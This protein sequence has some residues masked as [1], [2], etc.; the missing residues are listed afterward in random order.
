MVNTSKQRSLVF[1][2][3]SFTFATDNFTAVLI[4]QNCMQH[5]L[6]TSSKRQTLIQAQ[7]LA[8]HLIHQI[9]QYFTSLSLFYKQQYYL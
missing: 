4:I 6:E 9:Y 3:S 8:G 7:N 5:H 2:Q 1:Q